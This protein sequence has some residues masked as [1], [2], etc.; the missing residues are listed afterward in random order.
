VYCVYSVTA[1]S[2]ASANL[3]ATRA[4]TP[5]RFFCLVSCLLLLVSNGHFCLSSVVGGLET[6]VFLA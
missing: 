2:G 6:K 3:G 5:Q 1:G 4:P